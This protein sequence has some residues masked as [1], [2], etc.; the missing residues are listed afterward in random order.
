LEGTYT[1]SGG[2]GTVRESFNLD[3]NS[4][5]NNMTIQNMREID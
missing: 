1:G 4:M 3:S 2:P 5:A